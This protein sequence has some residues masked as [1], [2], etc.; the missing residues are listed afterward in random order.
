MISD[1]SIYYYYY[2]YYYYYIKTWKF[3]RFF[4]STERIDKSKSMWFSYSDSLRRARF[5]LFRTWLGVD[6]KKSILDVGGTRETWEGTGL[7][8]KVTLLNL[9]SPK[10]EDLQNG[11]TCVQGNA[12]DMGMFPDNHFGVVFSNS[13]I[14]HVGS[15]ENQVR[16]AREVRRVGKSYWVQTPNRYFPVEPHL[17]FPFFQFLP[18]RVQQWIAVNWTH[19]HLKRWKS[20]EEELLEELEKIRLLNR[21]E[22]ASLFTNAEIYS[23]KVYGLTKS[24][25]AYKV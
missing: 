1:D 10:T 6:S 25:V 13:V 12:L 16:F 9:T 5:A 15:F 22:L 19:S 18:E 4:L 17:M 2:Y 20:D 21:K 24:L 23:E 8:E 3:R 14:E 7:E 11:F